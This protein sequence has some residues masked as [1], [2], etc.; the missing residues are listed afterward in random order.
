MDSQSA[1]RA[2]GQ[3]TI[4]SSLVLQCKSQLNKLGQKNKVSVQWIPGHQDYK[5]NEVADRLAK[6]GK[7]KTEEGPDSCLPVT[8]Q[9]SRK[10]IKE[11]GLK[12]HNREWKE[13]NQD[14][15]ARSQK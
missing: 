7:E 12:T 13:R 1:I 9:L 10:L 5:G 2:L 15:H 3:F 6:T 14:V 4:D 8:K 11:W